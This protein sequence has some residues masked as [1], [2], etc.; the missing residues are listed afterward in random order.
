VPYKGKVYCITT[1][2]NNNVFI[3]HNNRIS[4]SGQSAEFAI[5]AVDELT[6]NSYETF[7]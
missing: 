4:I 5:I 3:R 7:M 1:N 6:K 2:P